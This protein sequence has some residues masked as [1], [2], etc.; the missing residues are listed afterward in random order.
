MLWTSSVIESPST[1]ASPRATTPPWSS[2][3]CRMRAAVSRSFLTVER[4]HSWPF[5]FYIHTYI[6]YTLLY[7]EKTL[8]HCRGRESFRDFFLQRRIEGHLEKWEAQS[9]R[10]SG[11]R[12]GVER[13]ELRRRRPEQQQGCPRRVLRSL[14]R[15]LQE[16][17]WVLV[18]TTTTSSST[19][20]DTATNPCTTLFF[21]CGNVILH[22]IMLYLTPYSPHSPCLGQAGRWVGRQR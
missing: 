14:V 21:V 11:Q 19:T 1:S 16:S 13:R 10:P 17:R 12:E 15:P 8:E 22:N 20:I 3:T 2:A 6:R 4:Y 5:T 7:D 18:A 9:W